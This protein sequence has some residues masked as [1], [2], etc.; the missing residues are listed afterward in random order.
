MKPKG[1]KEVDGYDTANHLLIQDR[2]NNEEE[3]NGARRF[4]MDGGI[5]DGT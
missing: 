3:V 1:Q 5:K 2:D 4:G